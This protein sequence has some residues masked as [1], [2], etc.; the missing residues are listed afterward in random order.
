MS[1]L[2]REQLAAIT[3]AAERLDE[4]HAAFGANPGTSSID[5][6]TAKEVMEA[7]DGLFELLNT[8]AV[9]ELV[10]LAERGLACETAHHQGTLDGMERMLTS[11][12]V[13]DDG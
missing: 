9:R 3:A 13:L 5:E 2:T 12:G 6:P 4:A 1:S 11:M 10:R 8:D 7:D